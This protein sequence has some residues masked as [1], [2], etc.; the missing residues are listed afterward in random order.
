[1]ASILRHRRARRVIAA[2]LLTFAAWHACA[3][4]PDKDPKDQC[5]VG[6]GAIGCASERSLIEITTRRKDAN[7]LKELVQGK[8][9]SG[10][11]RLFDYGERVQAITAHGT[12]RTLV[13]RN[14]D[15]T[16]YW[17]AASWSRP[18]AECEGTPTAASLHQKLGLPGA[19]P[20]RDPADETA[21]LADARSAPY[22]DARVP[23]FTDG[24]DPD[25]AEHRVPVD[26]DARHFERAPRFDD[27]DR[28][29]DEAGSR[30][31]ADDPDPYLV[32]RRDRYFADRRPPLRDRWLDGEGDEEEDEDARDYAGPGYRHERPDTRSRPLRSSRYAHDCD[33][34]SVMSDADLAACRNLRR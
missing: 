16:P 33:I 11:C 17:I 26:S 25:L 2:A 21:G 29:F 7:A 20:Q 10:Q 22:R 8:L 34:K 3:A 9:A 32:A 27:P 1:M 30:Q 18:A 19:A 28:R 6:D 24:R 13:R 23:T 5:I 15:K 4:E 14:G 31:L 12:D